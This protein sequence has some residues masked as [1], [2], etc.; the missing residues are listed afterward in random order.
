MANQKRTPTAQLHL[1]EVQKQEEANH[2][3]T[4][5][6]VRRLLKKHTPQH[7]DH[8]SQKGQRP[9]QGREEDESGGE[10][11]KGKGVPKAQPNS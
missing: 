6:S 10:V 4:R 1:Y 3:S 9:P 2:V 8:R 11:Q 7:D 5:I